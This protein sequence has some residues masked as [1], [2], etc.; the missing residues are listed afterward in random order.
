MANAEFNHLIKSFPMNYPIQNTQW[1]GGPPLITEGRW[2]CVSSEWW[3]QV[4]WSPSFS[5]YY[6]RGLL[7]IG[8]QGLLI[9]VASHCEAQ[10]PEVWASV[11]AACSLSSCGSQA[12]EWRLDSCGTWASL[13]CGLWDLPGSG[14]SVSSMDRW[15]LYHWAI[16]EVQAQV[17]GTGDSESSDRCGK[18]WVWQSRGSAERA[19][20]PQLEQ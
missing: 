11:A 1:Q 12:L 5:G 2:A 3:H 6:E 19:P 4:I 15:V 10:L 13:L 9:G 16:R 18:E 8:V 7:F 20:L 17:L 14:R